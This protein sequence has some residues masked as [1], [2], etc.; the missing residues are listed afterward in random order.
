MQTIRISNRENE[1]KNQIYIVHL[2]G[3][4]LVEIFQS[5]VRQVGDMCRLVH[6]HQHNNN[7]SVHSSTIEMERAN[8]DLEKIEKRMQERRNRREILVSAPSLVIGYE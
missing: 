2:R 5:R 8:M 3:V 7:D 1:K 4:G 6:I